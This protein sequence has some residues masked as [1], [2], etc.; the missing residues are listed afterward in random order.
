M[1]AWIREEFEEDAK[2][3]R[4]GCEVG[5]PRKFE[6]GS[7]RVRKSSSKERNGL[8][9]VQEEFEKGAKKVPGGFKECSNR[10]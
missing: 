3:V 5:L 6:E 1:A 10:A 7:R 8:R 9:W 4:I 2:R